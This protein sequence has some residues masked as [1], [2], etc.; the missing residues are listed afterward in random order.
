MTLAT[1]ADPFA[2]DTVYGRA[3][4]PQDVRPPRAARCAVL[5]RGCVQ[6][7]AITTLM[8]DVVTTAVLP[9]VIRKVELL[10]TQIE[11]QRKSIK[12]QWKAWWGRKARP[13]GEAG[14]C[15]PPLTCVRRVCCS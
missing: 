9:F 5:T 4:S 8:R 7:T 13:P 10:H 3:L 2:P 15:V 6:V 1:T 11:G 12:Q 14:R